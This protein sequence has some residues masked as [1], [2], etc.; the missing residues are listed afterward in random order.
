[1]SMK[2]GIFVG[3]ALLIGII[4]GC[5]TRNVSVPGTRYLKNNIHAQ[6]G[7]HDTKASYANWTDPGA[8]HIVIPVN[9]EVKFGSFRRGITVTNLTD[10]RTIYF[11]YSASYMGMSENDYINLISSST[12]VILSNLTDLDQ[13]GIKE[14]KVY[15]GMTKDGVRIALGYPATNRTPSLQSNT[16]IYW[17]N[18]FNTMAVEFD[19]SGRVKNIRD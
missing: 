2:K 7:G 13:K 16:W 19:D 3:I 14:G 11:E 10:S 9:T 6:A 5:H 8:G 4:I 12:P 15:S 1:M 18:R 17:K